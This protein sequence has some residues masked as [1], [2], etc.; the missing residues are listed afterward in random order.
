M[1]GLLG[2]P[3]E[4]GAA[5][6]ALGS[7]ATAWLATYLVHSTALLVLAWLAARCVRGPRG[8]EVVWRAALLGGLVTATLQVGSGA[9]PAFG[10]YELG[11]R[12][13]EDS[14]QSTT[15]PPLP[16]GFAPAFEEHLSLAALSAESNDGAAASLFARA[17]L[18]WD[19]ELAARDL[20]HVGP[21]ALVLGG[22]FAGG[23]ILCGVLVL[24]RR[25]RAQVRL[26][27]GS[28]AAAHAELVA[29]SRHLAGVELWSCR[30]SD[31]P[32]ASGFLRPRIVVPARAA[33]D[34]SPSE[35]RAM[36]AH[37]L[38]HIERHDPLWLGLTRALQLCLPLQPLNA[39][40]RR[41]LNDCAELLC[42]AR[43]IAR[44]GDRLAL[45]QSLAKVAG[46][47]VRDDSLPDA[48]CA[49]ASHRSLLGK[50]VAR[51]LDE[52]ARTDERGAGALRVAAVVVLAGTTAAAPM[53]AVS[54]GASTPG[55]GAAAVRASADIAPRLD[56]LDATRGAAGDSVRAELGALATLLDEAVRELDA[57]L[58]A[59]RAAASGRALDPSRTAR[60]TD[61]E[62]RAGAVRARAKRI[63]ALLTTAPPG[64]VEAPPQAR[65][66][67]A[68]PPADAR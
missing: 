55:A 2:S 21:T 57:E 5:L 51:I 3:G 9:S 58:A 28:L 11:G 22:G 43:A 8:R 12:V 38:A 42:D 10:R 31:T 46:W 27:E 19:A 6:A 54:A 25:R 48:A 18:L 68:A 26:V 65:R 16:A 29:G 63:R 30:R 41:R 47:L 32:Y 33:T 23:S 39:L 20:A 50:R 35:Q 14:V 66:R 40:A 52:D 45:A 13:S 56:S 59:L 1:S 15:A 64:G 17:L 37:E 24:R 34:L 36:L 44:T 7:L 49:M 53:V 61:L 4:L 62:Q 67:A 60:I